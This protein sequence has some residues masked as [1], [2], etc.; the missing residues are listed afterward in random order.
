MWAR[1]KTLGL[2]HRIVKLIAPTL[3]T[4]SIAGSDILPRP[5]IVAVKSVMDSTSLVGAEIGTA[6]GVHAESILKTLNIKKLYLIDPY[7]VYLQ[8][9]VLL[10]WAPKAKAEAVRRPE[11]F[12]GRIQ[13]VNLTSDEAVTVVPDGLDFVYIDG[14]HDY[15][16]VKNDI[17][18]YYLKARDGGVV[19]GHDFSTN[20]F[21]VMYG[22]L[23]FCK[24]E[25]RRKNLQAWRGDWWFVK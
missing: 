21:G 14:N 24:P 25:F 16:H 15:E 9:G 2:R 19:G 3:Y 1:K 11:H 6:F 22:V 7:E 4:T 20:H 12:G 8:D 18:N 13:F 10:D 23:E 17:Q 5:A